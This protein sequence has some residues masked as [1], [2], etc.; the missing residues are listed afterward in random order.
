MGSRLDRRRHLK[1]VREIVQA[2]LLGGPGQLGTG[3]TSGRTDPQDR[4]QSGCRLE[5]IAMA[6]RTPLEIQ[7]ALQAELAVL[8]QDQ[9][10]LDRAMAT[11]N[12]LQ[13]K[14]VEAQAKVNALM[15]ELQLSVGVVSR[16][17]RG[18]VFNRLAGVFNIPME[19]S[20]E[21]RP[22]GR[23]R[24]TTTKVTKKPVK[25]NFSPQTR[26]DAARRAAEMQARRKGLSKAKIRAA[27]DAAADRKRAQLRA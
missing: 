27:G 24:K 17:G 25:R 20:F 3:M 12:P 5:S 14:V 16:R 13:S 23:S 18:F 11:I 2:K 6:N 21:T 22:V 7:E 4:A 1:T 19:R 15:V 8:T 10:E 26:I 9:S